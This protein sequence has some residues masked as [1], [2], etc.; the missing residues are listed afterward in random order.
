MVLT[1][2]VLEPFLTLFMLPKN[3]RAS[4]ANWYRFVDG[5]RINL[6]LLRTARVDPNL[7]HLLMPHLSLAACRNKDRM[8]VDTVIEICPPEV[9]QGLTNAKDRLGTLTLPSRLYRSCFR[10]KQPSGHCFQRWPPFNC[11]I[12]ELGE[13]RIACCD[14][15]GE[16]FLNPGKMKSFE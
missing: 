15:T 11:L 1:C 4:F 14:L 9:Q 10:V 16:Y 13:K 12:A 5:N 3:D 6:V 8:D 2:E 7:K